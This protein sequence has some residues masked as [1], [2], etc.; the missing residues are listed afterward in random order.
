MQR[1][2]FMKIGLGAC[3]GAILPLETWAKIVSFG[4]T[5]KTVEVTTEITSQTDSSAEIWIPMPLTKTSYQRLLASRWEG[6]FKTAQLVRE[7]Q[8]GAD[9]LYVKWDE[10][11]PAKM[12]VTWKVKVRNRAGAEAT[13]PSTAKIYLQPTDHVPLDGI[14]HETAQKIVGNE[15]NPDRK[16]RLIYDWI[17]ENSVRDPAVRGC[18][19]GDVK[20]LLLSGNLKGKCADLSSLFVGLC[21]AVGVPAREV[22]GLRVLPSEMSKV[23]GKSGDVSKSQHCRAEYFSPKKGWIPVDPADVRKVILEENL[24]AKDPRVTE[25]RER[26]FGA[27][28]MNWIAFNSARDCALPPKGTEKV[29]YMMYPRLVAGSVRKDGMEPDQFQYKIESR[30]V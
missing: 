7:K 21:R 16:A 4:P 6:N 13:S 27:W 29:N 28:E 22:F 2:E 17:A 20:T 23:L 9:L 25:I 3:A 19:L 8:Y 24:A 1:R 14:V 10:P 5:W 26:L 12:T 30:L 11:G 18:G 15:K